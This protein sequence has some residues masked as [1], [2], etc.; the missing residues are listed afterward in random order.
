VLVVPKSA[1]SSSTFHR[2]RSCPSSS[3]AASRETRNRADWK[4]GKPLAAARP[5]HTVERRWPGMVA[6]FRQ[7]PN[8]V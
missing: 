3:P 2:P 6:D 5:G 1:Y 7:P 4:R 8:G